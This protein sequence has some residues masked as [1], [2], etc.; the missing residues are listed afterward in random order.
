MD[1]KQAQDYLASIETLGIIPGLDEIR[2]LLQ[3]LRNPQEGLRIIHIAGTNGKGSV[4][5][6]I[7]YILAASGYKVGRYLSPAVI[8]ECE[9]IQ[10][11]QVIRSQ[12]QGEKEEF[13]RTFIQKSDIARYLSD[14]KEVIK[15]MKN[16]PTRFEIET[17]MAFLELKEKRCDIVVLETGM[18]GR[19]D[20]TNIVTLVECSVITSIS[21]DHMQF[22]GNTLEEIAKEKAGIIKENVPV[23][24]SMQEFEVKKI[25]EKKA[26]M[27]HSK[28]IFAE[29]NKAENI[30]HSLQGIDF[31]YAEKRK[32]KVHLPLLGVHQVENAL[33]AIETAK[34]LK[35][36][37]YHIT[38]ETIQKGLSYTIWQGRF[39]IL[40]KKPLIFA[41]GAHNAAAAEKLAESIKTYILESQ[42]YE[43]LIYVFG[44][45]KDKEVMK[46]IEKTMGMADIV[47]TVTLDSP[48]GLSCRELQKKIE[49]FWKRIGKR[50]SIINCETVENGIRNALKLAKKED[51]I[52]IF[53]SLSLLHSIYPIFM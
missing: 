5:A 22:L 53:G 27:S 2:E 6:Y 21:M 44:M 30:V 47:F 18:G 14:I 32:W 38:E 43:K 1:Y 28:I 36:K 12:K 29:L 17:A 33:T 42:K 4:A 46:V 24:S 23:V 41:D 8:D 48:R 45:F 51:A 50:G 19:F 13:L 49:S 35:N 25:L 11:L 34:V 9:K 15:K 7:S 40:N 37:G 10:T 52:V 26:Q 31:I 20:A 3:K 39:E 16:H